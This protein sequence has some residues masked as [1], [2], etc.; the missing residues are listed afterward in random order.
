MC[1]CKR[2]ESYHVP[3]KQ[4]LSTPPPSLRL[5]KKKEKKKNASSILRFVRVLSFYLVITQACVK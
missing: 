5:A 2:I 3:L 1:K 4:N